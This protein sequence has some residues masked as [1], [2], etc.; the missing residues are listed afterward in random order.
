MMNDLLLNE[1][2]Q[3]LSDPSFRLTAERLTLK[4]GVRADLKGSD[5]LADAVI[6]YGTDTCTAFCEIYRI[7]GAVHDVKP[8]SIMRAISYAI[9]Q[10]FDLA[11]RLSDM[12]GTTIPPDHVHSGLVIAYLGRLFKNPEL[13][14]Y[15]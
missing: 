11:E 3:V 12:I 15:A 1:Y 5:S 8:K 6:L 2:K 9:T 7:I 10:A 4:C 14:L 13:S